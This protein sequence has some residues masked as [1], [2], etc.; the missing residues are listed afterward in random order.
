MGIINKGSFVNPYGVN[1]ENSYI[2]IKT[3]T[4]YKDSDGQYKL[5]GVY[6]IYVSEDAKSVYTPLDELQIL[7]NG[8]INTNAYTQL[9]NELKT[10]YPNHEDVL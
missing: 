9:Y 2:R 3:V 7:I 1:I 6:Q 5:S 10:V 8:D 4:Q